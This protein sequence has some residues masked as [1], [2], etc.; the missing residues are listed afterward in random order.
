MKLYCKR[1]FIM[2]FFLITLFSV[3]YMCTTIL[4]RNIEIT[5]QYDYSYSNKTKL[6]TGIESIKIKNG[7]IL[8]SKSIFKY[9]YNPNK[10]VIGIHGDFLAVFKTDKKGDFVL[11]SPK[12]ISK[13]KLS[14]ITKGDIELLKVGDKIYEYNTKDAAKEALIGMFVS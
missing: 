3:T 8:F 1:M 2:S 10:Y 4:C 14:K 5:E 6:G 12:D 11:E 7:E 9:K 13:V